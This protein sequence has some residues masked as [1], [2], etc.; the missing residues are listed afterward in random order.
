MLNLI[1]PSHICHGKKT[2][3]IR[4]LWCGVFLFFCTLFPVS[5]QELIQKTND[6]FTYMWWVHSIKENDNPLK[7][8]VKTNH[9]AFIFDYEKLNFE[10]MLIKDEDK[11]YIENLQLSTNDFFTKFETPKLSFG[12]E[13]G[14]RLFSCDHSSLRT[15][16]CQ[17]VHS[18]RFLQHRFINWIPGLT[19]CDPNHSGL[20]MVASSDRLSLLLRVVPSVNL[21]SRAIVIHFTLPDNYR[22]IP[23]GENAKAYK[24]TQDGSGYI[25]LKTEKISNLQTLN[26]TVTARLQSQ[27]RFQAG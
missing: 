11:S 6:E 12:I 15:E 2:V 23:V 17:L 3:I 22:E 10:K 18:G 4:I 14:G 20:E 26:N 21:R 25:F 19:G 16:D 13:T 7:F 8:A 27:E 5:A 9:Y 1:L 24:N